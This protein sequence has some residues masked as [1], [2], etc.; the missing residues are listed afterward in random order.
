VS[1]AFSP[2]E[3]IVIEGEN[4]GGKSSLFSGIFGYQGY[5]VSSGQIFLEG[6]SIEKLSLSEKSSLSLF[7]SPQN[8]PTLE[9][10]SLISFLYAFYKKQ[11]K[12][13]EASIIQFK[14]DIEEKVLS[15]SFRGDLLGRRFG[16]DF[17]GGEKKQVEIIQLLI[18]NADYFF[19]DEIDAGLD[20]DKVEK[21]GGLLCAL[22]EQGKCIIII[23]HNSYL[24]KLLLPEKIYQVKN[25]TLI[26]SL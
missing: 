12:E 6:K 11:K 3:I 13:D 5:E 18:S 4:G 9:G 21:L 1:A 8:I 26:T 19:L 24:K 17:S 2:H 22:R 23:T 7:Y 25:N 14:K 10:I 20:G 15:L 16:K